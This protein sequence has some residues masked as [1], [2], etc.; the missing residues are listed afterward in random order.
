MSRH[1]AVK[2]DAQAVDGASTRAA[3]APTGRLCTFRAERWVRFDVTRVLGW[4][5]CK[6]CRQTAAFAASIA[7]LAP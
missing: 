1:L 2:G 5:T 6:R 3:C 4:V 7:R